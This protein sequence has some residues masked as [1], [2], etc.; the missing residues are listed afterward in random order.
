MTGRG[1]P[2][3]TKEFGPDGKCRPARLSQKE[4]RTGYPEPYDAAFDRRAL[5]PKGANK[6][7]FFTLIVFSQPLLPFEDPV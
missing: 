4:T 7:Y 2:R 3:K 6:L 5:F 1:I